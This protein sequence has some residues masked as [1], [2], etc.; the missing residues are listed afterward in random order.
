MAPRKVPRAALY[1]RYSTDKQSEASVEDQFRVCERLAAQEGFEIVARFEDRGI[2][3]GTANRPGYQSL[4]DAARRHEFTAVLA[5]DLKRLWRE[6]AEQ[7]RA[8]KELIDLRICVVTASGIDSRQ[9]NFEIIASV[10]GAAAELDRKESSYRTRRGLEGRAV[11]GKSAGGRAYGYIPA[12]ASPSGEIAIHDM[13]AAI[14]RRIFELYADGI[15]PRSIAGTMNVEGVPS[16]GTSWNRT[17]VGPHAK[18]QRKWVA[19]AI[20]GDARRGVGILNNERYVG[21]I[22]W[23]RFK[24]RRGA[25]DSSKRTPSLIDDRSQWVTRE[26]PRLR[27]VSDELWQRVK[28]GQGIVAASAVRV[29]EVRAGRPTISLLSGLLVCDNCGSRFIAV[30]QRCYGCASHKNGGL[31]ACANTARVNRQRTESLILAEIE[32]EILS[33]EAVAQAQKAIRD[34]L[35]RAQDAIPSTAPAVTRLAKL[36]AEAGELRAMW[37]AGTLSPNAA[38]AALDTLERERVT[39]RANAAGRDWKTGAEIIRVIPQTAELYRAAVRNL[40]STLTERGERLQARALVAELL[41]G[42]VIV[43]Q[44]GEAVFAR[45][46]LDTGILA[47]R[48]SSN[49]INCFQIGS[50]GPLHAVPVAVPLPRQTGTN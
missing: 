10:V 47:S 35:R 13:Q 40:N 29:R 7:W 44:E 37:N 12:S 26:E 8:I 36:D 43:R 31:A 14:V 24:W 2:S 39:L 49:Q 46:D 48:G 25:A 50:G 33:D 15:S 41:G 17:A 23:G 5:E 16:P 4:L 9:Q 42:K 30:D 34:E 22:V 28:D 6:Q 19:S 20:N 11:A 21:R 32:T 18:R 3:G 45:L 27:I 38:Q 1:A